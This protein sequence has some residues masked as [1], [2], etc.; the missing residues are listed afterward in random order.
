MINKTIAAIRWLLASEVLPKAGAS[1]ETEGASASQPGFYRWLLQKDTLRPMDPTCV[2]PPRQQGFF[3]W[4]L[5]QTASPLALEEPSR[6]HE[7]R[8]GLWTWLLSGEEL[9]PPEPADRDP[10]SRSNFARRLLAMEACPVEHDVVVKRTNEFLRHLL[11][12]EQ[13]PVRPTEAP[14]DE[15][16]FCSWLLTRAECPV[17]SSP[18]PV[19]RQSF[20]RNLLAPEQL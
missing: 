14:R 7:Q 15:Q 8:S 4:V 16:S 17:D 19:R 3:S 5:S 9:P 6:T 13:C 1:D 12:S 11:A 2:A 18:A 10:S 20:W